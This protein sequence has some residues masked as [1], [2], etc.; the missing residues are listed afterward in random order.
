MR[1]DHTRSLDI[2]ERTSKCFEIVNL[3]IKRCTRFLMTA[4]QSATLLTVNISLALQYVGSLCIIRKA[5]LKATFNLM[6]K[7]HKKLLPNNLQLLISLD[8]DRNHI[9]RQSNTFKQVFARTTL[10]SQ[11]ISVQGIKLWNSLEN[12]IKSSKNIFM[13]RKLYKRRTFQLYRT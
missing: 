10:K 4:L 8:S 2:I 5:L 6:Y 1:D 12:S 9:T 13:F 11:C 3:V 7:A